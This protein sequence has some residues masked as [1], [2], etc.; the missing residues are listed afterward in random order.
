MDTHVDQTKEWCKKTKL[1][2]ITKCLDKWKKKK[3]KY[4]AS[5]KVLFS[6]SAI[7][8]SEKVDAI[9]SI[10]Y[11]I[12]QRVSQDDKHFDLSKRICQWEEMVIKLEQP[13]CL[14]NKKEENR[15]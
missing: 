14:I 6:P 15:L 13:L 5:D 11:N 9:A 3:K 7:K 2:V 10:R 8:Q 12:A 1:Y 4:S